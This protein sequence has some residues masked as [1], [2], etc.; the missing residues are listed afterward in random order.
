M[1]GRGTAFD[2]YLT[3]DE[4]VEARLR[5]IFKSLSPSS[6][7]QLGE[8]PHR[9]FMSTLLGARELDE[10]DGGAAIESREKGTLDHAILESFYRGLSTSE[11]AAAGSG[12]L[13]E[14]LRSRLEAEVNRTFDE[15][16]T[17]TPAPNRALRGIERGETLAS[18]AEFVRSDLRQLAEGNWLPQE[19]EL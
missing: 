2:G 3:V 6:L 9:F 11:F 8:C 12:E 18:L 14:A 19:Y 4:R 5:G 13:P 15:L 7:E 16:D 17:K 1:H 10:P